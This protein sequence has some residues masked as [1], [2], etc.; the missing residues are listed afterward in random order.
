MTILTITLPEPLQAFVDE[1]VAKG[2]YNSAGEYLELLI[3]QA[4]EQV[5]CEL[6]HLVN[7]AA[8]EAGDCLASLTPEE[9]ERLEGLLREGLNSGPPIEVNEQFWQ[10][11]LARLTAD[12]SNTEAP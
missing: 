8:A 10:D 5:E 11:K 4:R 2:G 3:Y 7:G 6:A 12:H 1:E 9:Q